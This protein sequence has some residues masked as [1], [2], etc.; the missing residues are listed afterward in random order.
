MKRICTIIIIC[1]SLLLQSGCGG[2][3]YSNFRELEMLQLVR[4]MGLDRGDG[5]V[6]VT[7]SSGKGEANPGGVLLSVTAPS[8]SLAEQ[9]LHDFAGERKLFYAHTKHLLIGEETAKEG[10][11]EFLGA[12]ERSSLLRMGIGLYLVRGSSAKELMTAPGDESYEISAVLSSVEQDLAESGAGA[13]FTCMETERAL[14][15]CGACL[16]CALSA[17]ETETVIYSAEAAV[18]AVPDGFGILSG[19]VLVGSIP[20]ADAPAACIL[21]NRGALT[22]IVLPCGEGSASVKLSKAGVKYS[23]PRQGL[24]QAEVNLSAELTELSVPREGDIEPLLEELSAALESEMRRRCEAV[25][26]QEKALKADF[27]GLSRH[28][29]DADARWFDGFADSSEMLDDLEIRLAVTAR[30][31]R[32]GDLKGSA[33]GAGA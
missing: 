20:R 17:A 22:D 30:V 9:S 5:G 29:R 33:G 32:S 14:A 12:V 4:V 13:V 1:I 23:L 6:T 2:T 25:L 28:V 7:V 19:G 10:I 8:L 18:T 21:L 11:G 31:G 24:L 16:I 15:D 3:V 26:A 27:L